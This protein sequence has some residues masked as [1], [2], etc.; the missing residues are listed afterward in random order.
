M[1]KALL[2]GVKKFMVNEEGIET[3]EYAIVAGLVVIA[4][5]VA[6]TALGT[7]VS[8]SYG[9]VTSKLP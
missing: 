8:A 7:K 6:I 2:S 5:V 3:V 1:M 9:T 4:A